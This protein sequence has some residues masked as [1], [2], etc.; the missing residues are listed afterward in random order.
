MTNELLAPR[1]KENLASSDERPLRCSQISWS[2]S[3]DRVSLG[4][5]EAGSP[6]PRNGSQHSISQNRI[7]KHSARHSNRRW[8]MPRLRKYDGALYRRKDTP[9]WWIRYRDRSGV[10]RAESSFTKD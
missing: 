8:R 4:R 5:A 7:S 10:R 2:E 9:F 6:S 3:A 1:E